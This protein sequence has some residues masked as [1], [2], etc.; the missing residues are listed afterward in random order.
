V[1][2]TGIGGGHGLAATLRAARTYADGIAAV[3]T[4]ADDGGSSGRLTRE[5]GVPPPGDIRNCLV[6][7]AD[8]S[9]LA[10]LYQHRFKGGALAGHTLGNLLIA[11]LTEMTGD[12]AAAVHRAGELLGA[13][14][15]VH[16]ATT[17]LVDM[18]ALVNDAVVH[19]QVAVAQTEDPIRAVYLE[20]PNP[21]AH[22][23]AV[24][25]I[26]DAD[27]VILGP[28]SLFTSLLATLLV[29]GIGTALKETGA[30]RILVT[31][32]RA[33]RGETSGLDAGA[34][35][36]AVLAHTGARCIDAVVVQHPVIDDDGVPYDRAELDALGIEVCEADVASS[37]GPHD[38]GRLG[39]ALEGLGADR[40]N[41][42]A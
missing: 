28:G 20:P 41:L 30:K 16:P 13:R 36:T 26:R 8:E 1:K 29:P 3:V 37:E 34:H 19:G 18:R 33:Q 7:L 27:Q 6:A 31:N 9:E 38:P 15:K 42:P 39:A 14:G 32:T 10:S 11:A 17:E 23:P 22:S 25:A 35:V 24:A 40:M 5:L 12:F 21:S 4:V 2:V